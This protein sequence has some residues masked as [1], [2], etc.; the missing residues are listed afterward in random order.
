MHVFKAFD[1]YCQIEHPKF[2]MLLSI[3][4]VPISSLVVIF[5]FC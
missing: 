1:L 4:K 3:L 5:Q 2:Y